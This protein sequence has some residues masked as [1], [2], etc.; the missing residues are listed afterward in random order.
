MRPKADAAWHLH[1]LTAAADLDAFV[2][3]SSAAATFGSAG[4]GNYAAANAYLD[5]L[6]AAR[7][8]AGLPAVSL[9]WGMWA[10]ATGLT[11]RLGEADQARISRGGLAG[12]TAARGLALLDAALGRDEPLL[13]PAQLD[14]AG[15]RAAAARGERLPRLWHAL[16]VPPGRRDRRERRDRQAWPSG[17]PPVRR[18]RPAPWPRGWPRY[19]RPTGTPPCSTWSAATSPRC[20]ATPP[21]TPSRPTG[22]SPTWASTP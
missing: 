15:L 17:P 9:A 3:F 21:R 19:P 6:A 14:V 5:A 13:V 11:G 1:E 18:I 2:L 22:P 10:D 16:I 20:S 4:Q 12:L 8:A 7:Q